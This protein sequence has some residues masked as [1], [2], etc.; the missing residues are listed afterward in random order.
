MVDQIY[1]YL[2][3]YKDRREKTRVTLQEDKRK[4]EREKANK[5]KDSDSSKDV[6]ANKDKKKK[7]LLLNESAHILS[8]YIIISQN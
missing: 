1:D 5:K 2:A 8:D 3:E 6:D 7:D 4:K